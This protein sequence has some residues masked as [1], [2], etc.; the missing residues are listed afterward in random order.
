MFAG[1]SEI[2]MTFIRAPYIETAGPEVR[3]LATVGGR[4]VAAE[5]R[6]ILATAFHPELTDDLRVLHYFLG[7]VTAAAGHAPQGVIY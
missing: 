1:L 2:P 6:N 3:V 7:K 5:S 4:A